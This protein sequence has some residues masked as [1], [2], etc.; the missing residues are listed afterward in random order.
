MLHGI[1]RIPV[2]DIR[3]EADSDSE[4]RSQAL[5]GTPVEIFE[6]G[7]RFSK[8]ALPGRY[9]GWCRTEH[10]DHVSFALWRKYIAAPKHRVKAESVLI[11]RSA[12]R[13]SYPYR[14]FFGTELVIAESGKTAFFEIP[15]DSVRAP[16]AMRYLADPA[17]KGHTGVTGKRIVAT[18][19]RFSGV[20]YLWGGITPL[21]F[22][23]SGLVKSVFGFHGI[24]LPRDSRDQRNEGFEVAR[25]SVNPGD[26][27]FFPG[28]V[29]ISCGGEEFVHASASRGMVAIDSFDP[30]A[31][32]YR[33]DL[34]N[35]FEYARR[36]SL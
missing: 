10:I 29:A 13:F 18:A 4:R 15:G 30:G 3:A 7:K 27:L 1:I 36:I 23:C 24:T 19:V 25:A 33:E 20:P 17:P 16:I 21:G 6:A 35:D 11:K 32:N 31:P 8:V 22:D 5:F 2:T 12:R 34:D 28:H 26:L 9:E 14:L